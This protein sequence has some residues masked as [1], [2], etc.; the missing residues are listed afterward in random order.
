[1]TCKDL[2]DSIGN[3]TQYTVITYMR[4]DLKIYKKRNICITDSLCCMPETNKHCKSTI[5][6]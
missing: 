4:N 5:S 6:Q 2:L 3:F 1:M